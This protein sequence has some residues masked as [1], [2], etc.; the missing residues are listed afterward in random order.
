[1]M[2]DVIRGDQPTLS[3]RIAEAQLKGE[4]AK[5]VGMT[6]ATG[7]LSSVI[8]KDFVEASK[9]DSPFVESLKSGNPIELADLLDKHITQNGQKG[10]LKIDDAMIGKMSALDSIFNL[11]YKELL[12]KL[13]PEVTAALRMAAADGNVNTAEALTAIGLYGGKLPEGQV[14]DQ[15]LIDAGKIAG[16]Y[17]I[18]D[19][20]NTITKGLAGA[21]TKIFPAHYGIENKP[22]AAPQPLAPEAGQPAPEVPRILVPG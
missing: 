17:G 10:G 11:K 8:S 22:E 14:P 3:E 1:M 9:V 5:I 4:V 16:K 12:D 21:F 20:D 18:V 7:G 6:P 15:A 2:R 19:P 13:S